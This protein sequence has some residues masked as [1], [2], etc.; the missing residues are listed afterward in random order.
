LKEGKHEEAVLHYS[1]AI[2]LDEKNYS[3]FSNRSLAFL[4]MQQFYLALED[5]KE[6]IKLK[7]DWAKG[8]F[9]KGEVAR[10]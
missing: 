4:K 10:D 9:R 8:Y 7:P 3:L 2:R 6:T 5:A 1:Q